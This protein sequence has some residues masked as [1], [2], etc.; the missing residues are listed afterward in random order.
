MSEESTG[1][2]TL[3][4]DLQSTLD[5][6]RESAGNEEIPSSVQ[7]LGDGDE[8]QRNH[9]SRA[10]AEKNQQLKTAL[11]VIEKQSARINDLQ[12]RG[13]ESTPAAGTHGQP[14]A[15]AGEAEAQAA[16]VMSVLE[17]QALNNLG[18]SSKE[19]APDMVQ[20][21]VNRLYQM[22]AA[23]LERRQTATT[24]APAFVEQV[25]GT[26]GQLTDEDK[27]ELKQRLGKMDVLA[28]TN[29]QVVRE[30][31]ALYIGQQALAGRSLSGGGGGEGA[32][33][34]RGPVGDLKNAGSMGVKP[35]E[36]APK[37]QQTEQ[38]ATPEELTE[39]K[40]LRMT[41]LKAFRAAKLKQKNY[42]GR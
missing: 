20:L 9:A 35:G 10:F 41:D 6:L 42:A 8:S 32:G 4:A 40:A 17:R 39:M 18:L 2:T 28:Q 23:D 5:L 15:G 14:S 33:E 7:A 26:F 11:S 37:G 24:E 25:L 22:Q 3:D 16:M 38:P 29:E 1:T 21:E 13:N 31:V 36:Q 12:E 30:Q 34:A 19:Q 27:A